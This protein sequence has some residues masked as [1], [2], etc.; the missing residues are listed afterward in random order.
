MTAFVMHETASCNQFLNVLM[1]TGDRLAA[2][3]EEHRDAQ[4]LGAVRVLELASFPRLKELIDT[5]IEIMPRG[6]INQSPPFLVSRDVNAAILR[7]RFGDHNAHSRS[8][9]RWTASLPNLRTC[10]QKEIAPWLVI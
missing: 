10:Y 8:V 3:G 1:A 7:S 5:H 4:H 2:N 6:A 9:V